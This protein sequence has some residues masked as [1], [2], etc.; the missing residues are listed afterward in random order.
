[1]PDRLASFASLDTP[2]GRLWASGTDAGLLVIT[3]SDG[4][5]PLLAELER[6]GWDA[7]ADPDALTAA[8]RELE[9]Y[10]AGALRS[11]SLAL[12][13]GRL[14]AFHA[15]V[16]RAAM[17]IQYGETATYGEVAAMAGSPRAARAVGRAMASCPLFP[18]VP[19]HRV[20]HADG[21]IHGWGRDPWV[22]R[23][24]LEHERR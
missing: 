17:S 12:D 13:L 14:P 16:Y 19:C 21:S 15:A 24:L 1:M 3:R 10:F 9:A 6:R 4:P 8:L 20:I 11:F 7:V 18:V 5:E 23:W 22:K 2:I